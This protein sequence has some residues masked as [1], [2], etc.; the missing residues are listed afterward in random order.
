MPSRASSPLVEV[1]LLVEQPRQRLSHWSQ[2]LAPLDDAAAPPLASV[3]AYYD[4]ASNQALFGLRY[5]EQALG[6]TG[7]SYIVEVALLAEVGMIQ[8]AEL[9]EGDRRR[10]VVDRLAGCTVHVSDQR[11]V[12]ASLVELVRRV[13]SQRSMTNPPALEDGRR[14]RVALERQSRE[15]QDDRRERVALEA[16]LLPRSRPAIAPKVR[17]RVETGES[18]LVV[19]A[20]GTRNPPSTESQVRSSRD[21]ALGSVRQPLDQFADASSEAALSTPAAGT[22]PLVPREADLETNPARRAQTA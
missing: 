3:D 22:A 4:P 10:F 9:S 12:V 20:K 16:T 19:A 15:D 17:A 1:F 18:L 7:M 13:R 6:A 8:P 21:L 11:K 14:E 5:D 2:A